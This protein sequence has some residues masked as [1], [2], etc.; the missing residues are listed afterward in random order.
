V[1]GAAVL[2]VAAL[3]VGIG[4]R[5]AARAANPA[6]LLDVLRIG[7]GSSGLNSSATPAFAVPFLGVGSGQGTV[8]TPIPLPTAQ[9]GSNAPLTMS[10]TASS[11]GSLEL[12]ANGQYLTV[13]GYDATPGTASVA[14][15]TTIPR[16]AGRIDGAG[17][18]D[19][20]TVLKLGSFSGNNVRGAITND[21]SEFWVTGAGGTRAA[22]STHHSGTA[23]PLPP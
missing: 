7:S 4:S 14:S 12:S 11:E 23:P 22:S 1:L 10:G 19:T 8:G 6:D 3:A 15:S 9:S 13:A 2:G 21:G 5:S 20:S 16:V 17:N 18:I